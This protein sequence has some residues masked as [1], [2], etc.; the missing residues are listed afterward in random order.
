MALFLAILGLFSLCGLIILGDNGLAELK[1]LK[2]EH[3]RMVDDNQS[4]ARKNS[5]LFREVQRLKEDIVYIENVA[6][7]QLGFIG[8]DEYIFKLKDSIDETP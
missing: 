6:L 5:I 7:Q 2:Q 4:L 8:K 1:F 3:H